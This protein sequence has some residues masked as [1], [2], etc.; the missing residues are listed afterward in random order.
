MTFTLNKEAIALLTYIGKSRVGRYTNYSLSVALK[1]RGIHSKR[2][3]KLISS[4]KNKG[5]FRMGV[6]DFKK[7][8]FIEDSYKNIAHF[9]KLLDETK[10]KLKTN[11][12]LYYEYSILERI[13]G[14]RNPGIIAFKIITINPSSLQ[15][16]NGEKIV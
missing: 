8:L 14:K 11:A 16:I 9:K 6:D 2:I 7:V 3:Y 1:I 12:D 5:G 10:E 15:K 4:W 13:K